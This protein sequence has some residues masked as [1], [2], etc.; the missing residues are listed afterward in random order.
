MQRLMMMICGANSSVGNWQG[1]AVDQILTIYDFWDF[2]YFISLQV[3][4]FIRFSALSFIKQ[5]GQVSYPNGTL[6][7]TIWWPDGDVPEFKTYNTY[8]D[9]TVSIR[10]GGRVAHGMANVSHESWL[11]AL[12]EKG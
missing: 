3:S 4:C 11:Y 8:I 12:C 7:Y 9:I 5:D 1:L 2:K 10:K 6:G